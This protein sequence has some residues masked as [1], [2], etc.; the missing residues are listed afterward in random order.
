MDVL[1][2]F[3]LPAISGLLKVNAS[4]AAD[5]PSVAQGHRGVGVWMLR[6][7]VPQ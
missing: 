4:F 7:G 6:F 5:V 2:I 1:Y 3:Q